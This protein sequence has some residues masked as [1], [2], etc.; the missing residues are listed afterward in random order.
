MINRYVKFE[1]LSWSEV[2]F[3]ANGFGT[4]LVL[5]GLSCQL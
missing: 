1:V 2:R 3:R 5:E 4:L